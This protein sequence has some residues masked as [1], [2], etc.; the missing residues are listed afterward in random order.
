MC[1]CVNM[2][3]ILMFCGNAKGRAFVA[4]NGRGRFARVGLWEMLTK[5]RNGV[6][7]TIPKVVLPANS[8]RE[9]SFSKQLIT[10]C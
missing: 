6:G 8:L 1:V 5:V 4:L 7:S 2:K 9:N 3:S 10:Y